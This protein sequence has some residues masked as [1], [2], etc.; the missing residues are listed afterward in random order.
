MGDQMVK[1]AVAPIKRG[2]ALQRA[3]EGWALRV[4][5][6]TWQQIANAVG[7]ASAQGAHRAVMRFAG[8]I[9]DPDPS[10]LK[11]MWRARLDR[12]YALAD[13]D[14]EAARPGALRAASAIAQ[15]AAAMDG[16][17]APTQLNLTADA[18]ELDRMVQVLFAA[19]TSESAREADVFDDD[20]V[21]DA[22]VVG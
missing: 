7:F 17:D 3:S 1:T 2:D 20:D 11:K 22:E 19:T 16:L 14:A 8:T 13:R 18:A 10:V 21:V 15:R 12:L 5:G 9:P 4:Q 6:K